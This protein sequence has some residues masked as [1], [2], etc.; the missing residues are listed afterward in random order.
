[1][2]ASSVSADS[3]ASLRP[4]DRTFLDSLAS[5]LP[6]EGGAGRSVRQDGSAADRGVDRKTVPE[7]GRTEL[8]PPF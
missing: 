7:R 3:I 8:H 1:M 4:G 5:A 6:A 2:D